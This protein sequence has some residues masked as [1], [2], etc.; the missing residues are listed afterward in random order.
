MTSPMKSSSMGMSGGM[1]NCIYLRRTLYYLVKAVTYMY[2]IREL[3]GINIDVMTC[4]H[5]VSI[6]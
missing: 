6:Y 3:V 5:P 2:I 4:L 1:G